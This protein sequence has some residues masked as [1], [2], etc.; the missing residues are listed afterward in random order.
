VC[1]SDLGDHLDRVVDRGVVE[2]GS[3][4]RVD[5]LPADRRGPH[6]QLD[7]EVAERA[8]AR[9]ESRLPVVVGRVSRELVVGALCTE[10]VCMRNRSVVA[11]VLR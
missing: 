10:V 8:R 6:R 7:R 9:V 5:L 11:V 4:Q 3:A 1:S 2:A